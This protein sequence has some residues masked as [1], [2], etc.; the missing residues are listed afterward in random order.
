MND[1]QMH[2]RLE[3]AKGAMREAAGKIMGNKKL[4]RK[5]KKEAEQG[6]VQSDV[7]DMTAGIEKSMDAEAR[8]VEDPSK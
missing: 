5:G 6:K 1:N 2:G 8:G 3:V 4:A 7:G